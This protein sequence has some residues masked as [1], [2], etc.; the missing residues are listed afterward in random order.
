MSLNNMI[1]LF[2]F[3]IEIVIKSFGLRVRIE[4]YVKKGL[5]KEVKKK[6]K[7]IAEVIIYG[8]V[9]IIDFF[10]DLKGILKSIYFLVI[11]KVYLLIY[12]KS[13]L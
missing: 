3:I 6:R 2:K 9:L 4:L 13:I 5:S 11:N 12:I 8:C 1:L 7:I 10:I